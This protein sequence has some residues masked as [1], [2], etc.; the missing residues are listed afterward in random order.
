MSEGYARFII[1]S[2]ARTGSNLLQQAL[3]SHSEIVCFREIFNI[4]VLRPEVG[5]NYIDYEVEGWDPENAADI[6]LRKAD[7]AAFL[8]QRIFTAHRQQIRAV[9]FKFHY[10]HF[11]FHPDLLPA[12]TD[13]PALKVI[14]L[15]R[16]NQL[17]MFVS[18][19]LA[20]LTGEWQR[21]DDAKLRQKTLSQR[22]TP[23][24]LAR[25]VAHPT[26]SIARVRR[27][28]APVREGP[29]RV[30]P[31]LTISPEEC[32]EYFAR[33]SHQIE[34]FRGLFAGHPTAPLTYEDMVSDPQGELRRIQEF[35]GVAPEDP[36]WTSRR[37]NPE[38]L[39]ELVANYD[40]LRAAFAGTAEA[41]FFEE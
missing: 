14:H 26:A 21:Y 16:V 39:R 2:D 18:L 15:R 32:A 34:H 30:K 27:L 3:N 38:P 23:S 41:G 13:D 20:E 9:G 33:A 17:R 19:K 22:L 31:A 36:S 4:G 25:A 35:L 12:L 5:P 40:E 6:A 24:K 1:L 11:W 28:L 37:Q 29:T 10:D 8:K 7:P